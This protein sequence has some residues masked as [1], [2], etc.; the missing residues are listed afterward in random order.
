MIPSTL[1][2]FSKYALNQRIMSS[3]TRVIKH[4]LL[5]LANVIRQEN[6]ISDVIFKIKIQNYS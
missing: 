5:V 3:L 2:T 6:E 1:L 4:C